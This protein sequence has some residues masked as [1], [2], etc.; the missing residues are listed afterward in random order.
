MRTTTERQSLWLAEPGRTYPTLAGTATADVAV[1]GA[2]ITGLTTAL[3]LKRAGLRVAVVEADR[4]GHGA[5]GNNT[6]KV[7]ALQSTVY[8]ELT[9]RHGVA[10]ATSYAGASLA[11][12]ETVAEIVEREG[13]DCDLRHR[14]AVTYAIDESERASIAAEFAAAR[15]AGLNVERE[16]PDLPFPVYGGVRLDDQLSLHPVRYLRGLAAAV[17]GE[18]STVFQQSRVHK[19]RAGRVHTEGGAVRAEHVVIA[20]HAPLLD[21]GGYFARMEAV[22]SYCVAARLR[23]GN[24]PEALA[25]NAGDPVWSVASAGDLLIVSGQGHP[26]GERGVDMGRYGALEAFVR[27]HWDVAEIVHRWSAQDLYAYDGLPMI[28]PYLPGSRNLYVATGYRKWGLATATAA[29]EM[30]TDAINGKDH[31]WASVFS[32]YRVSLRALP[33]LARLNTKVAVDLVG[34][35]LRPGEVAD[36]SAVPPGEARVLRDGLERAGVYRD[37]DGTVHA[38]SLR[39]THLGCL[40][41]FNGAETSW[42]CPCHG[43]RFDVDGAVLEGPAVKPLPRKDF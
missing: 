30:L 17:A 29:A 4:V 14:P 7:S 2:G 1:V 36:P 19:V 11:G 13:I 40:L 28:G 5:S 34:D 10:T 18:G 12:V 6:A 37:E 38:V 23:S 20:T 15:G 42:D 33:H 8:S 22:R 39:C 43:S 16:S 31:P 3:Q 32:P 24:P 26:A 25:I 9:N 27:R 21:R 35:R 41:R